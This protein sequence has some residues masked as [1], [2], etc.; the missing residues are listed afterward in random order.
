[1]KKYDSIFKW[2][3]LVTGFTNFTKEKEREREGRENEKVSA[4]QIGNSKEA[5]N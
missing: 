3:K 1:M 4:K 5:D 2:E